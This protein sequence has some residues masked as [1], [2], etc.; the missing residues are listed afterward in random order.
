MDI[1]GVLFIIVFV[2]LGYEDFFLFSE[3]VIGV[4][5]LEEVPK[6][7]LLLI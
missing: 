3:L 7:V 6:I 4:I 5:L 1:S 2:T